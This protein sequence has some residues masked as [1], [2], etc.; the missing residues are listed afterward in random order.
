M[1]SSPIV[2]RHIFVHHPV[3]MPFVQHQ[4]LVQ[5]FCPDGPHPALGIGIR[6]WCAVRRMDDLD[7]LR[8]K[9]LSNASVNFPSLSCN[10]NR[11]GSGRSSRAQTIFLP[12]L[13]THFP[14]GCAVQAGLGRFSLDVIFG[15]REFSG[16][17]RFPW[18]TTTTLGIRS[19]F[20]I[21]L[22]W[23]NFLLLTAKSTRT[24]IG[25]SG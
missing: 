25:A 21:S 23:S 13:V 7:P 3:Q 16:G 6:V 15:I 17:T 8:A 12:Y 10:R 2:V 4:D 5:A 24:Q 20:A 19:A 1:Q 14:F 11:I 18:H 9:D 22:P